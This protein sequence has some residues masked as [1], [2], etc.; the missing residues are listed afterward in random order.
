MIF[1]HKIQLVPAAIL[2]QQQFSLVTISSYLPLN[3]RSWTQLS[4]QRR[5]HRYKTDFPPGFEQHRIIPLLDLPYGFLT[6][7]LLCTWAS[8]SNSARLT[9]YLPNPVC[10]RRWTTSPAVVV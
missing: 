8:W 4:K 2:H 6:I 5:T 9:R 10:R 3:T 7:L 1:S